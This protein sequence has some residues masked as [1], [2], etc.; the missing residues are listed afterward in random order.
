LKNDESGHECEKN[1]SLVVGGWGRGGVYDL[2][3]QLII[4]GTKKNQKEK[5]RQHGKFPNNSDRSESDKKQRNRGA[6]SI[7]GAHGGWTLSNLRLLFDHPYID[8]YKTSIEVSLVTAL[9]GGVIGMAIAYAAVREG[10]PTWIRS[11]LTTFS[12]VAANFG[13]IP[14][15]FAFIATLGTLGIVSSFLRGLGWDPY[16][17]GFSLFSGTC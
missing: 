2:V 6:K 9:L 17:H 1:K 14:L 11:I 5:A 15:A 10:T 3:N 8:A 13:G 7:K 16:N 4:H 12:G